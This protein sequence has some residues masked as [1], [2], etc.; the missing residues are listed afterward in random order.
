MPNI[1]NTYNSNYHAIDQ[2]LDRV[3]QKVSKEC[4]IKSL[5][6]NI[7]NIL[8]S[9]NEL[10]IS[11]LLLLI[12]R[13][14]LFITVPAMLTIMTFQ[15]PQ[16]IDFFPHNPHASQ[17]LYYTL[18]AGAGLFESFGIFKLQRNND[19]LFNDFLATISQ[20]TDDISRRIG[21]KTQ[22][23]SSQLSN[24][25]N[26]KNKLAGYEQK[27]DTILAPFQRRNR[28]IFLKYERQINELLNN[29]SVTT[30]ILFLINNRLDELNSYN[31]SID[32]V[33]EETFNKCQDETDYYR[34]Y[35]NN[36]FKH[37]LIGDN[38]NTASNT[39]NPSYVKTDANNDDKK[40]KLTY[41]QVIDLVS[42]KV[43][44]NLEKA[45]TTKNKLEQIIHHLD[46]KIKSSKNPNIIAQL[47]N[48]RNSVLRKYYQAI[49]AI[50]A[51]ERRYNN[52]SNCQYVHDLITKEKSEWRFSKEIVDKLYN[53]LQN[54]DILVLTQCVYT[55][56][57]DF[58]PIHPSYQKQVQEI[59]FWCFTNL[60]KHKEKIILKNQQ[61]FDEMLNTNTLPRKPANF[62]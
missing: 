23:T 28:N 46:E 51:L 47:Q 16:F 56:L 38:Q 13:N 32:Q 41:S 62:R 24:L 45:I 20:N 18:L 59:T 1:Q 58:L 14:S 34:D 11:E 60:L 42:Q 36:F 5:K 17:D 53:E 25:E 22:H 49:D 31:K 8:E 7:N 57:L 9:I 52:L 30:I 26:K 3:T 37:T 43:N 44:K 54:Y 33:S 40:Y 39:E 19:H 55:N 35:Y 12:A 21:Y 50:N 15:A 61:E 2:I 48:V 4:K 6:I 10:R 29:Y 27:L